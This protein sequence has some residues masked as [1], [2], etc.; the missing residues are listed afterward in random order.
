MKIVSVDIGNK[1]DDIIVNLVSMSKADD[2]PVIQDLKVR[3]SFLSKRLAELLTEI[4]D[5]RGSPKRIVLERGLRIDGILGIDGQ[6][7]IQISRL[8]VF[9]SDQE[10]D[11]VLENM[12]I[13]LPPVVVERFEHK[14]FY[15]L[16]GSWK[17]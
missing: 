16:R 3:S 15:Y 5:N 17:T 8:K 2:P 6:L 1:S 9:P 10:W 14:G 4:F 12:P 13:D 11:T 7:R